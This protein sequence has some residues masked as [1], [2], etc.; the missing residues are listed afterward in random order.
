MIYVFLA[1]GFEE[2]EAIAPIDL[3]RRAGVEVRAVGIDKMVTGSHGIAVQCDVAHCDVSAC[4]GIILPG[5]PGH[6]L[7]AQSPVVRNCLAAVA[8]RGG[9]LAAIC[10]A[11]SILGEQGYL[12]GKRATCYPGFEDK[13]TGATVVDAPVVTDGNVITAKAAGASIEFGL[14]CVEYLCGK[15]KADEVA[16]QICY[17]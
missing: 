16:T 17:D 6:K 9:M 8:E 13:L 7:L 15:E 14:A 12:Q 5:G 1:D 2:I 4:T 10:A 11:P 3:L